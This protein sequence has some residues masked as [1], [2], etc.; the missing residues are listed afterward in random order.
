MIVLSELNRSYWED[1]ARYLHFTKLTEGCADVFFFA[2]LFDYAVIPHLSGKP[3]WCLEFE[4]PNRY[5][6][7][8]LLRPFEQVQDRI[9]RIF[10]ICPYT[11]EWLNE[12]EGSDRRVPVYFPFAARHVPEPQEKTFDVI[13]TGHVWSGVLEFV[14]P[15]AAHQYCLVSRR[16][17]SDLDDMITHEDVG[18]FE[19]LRLIARSR[20]AVVHN[21]LF[22]NKKH[23]A[24]VKRLPGADRNKAF[25]QIFQRRDVSDPVV[26]QLKSRLFEAAFCRTLILCARDDW[27]VAER[28]FEPEQEFLYYRRGALEET[29]NQ[30]LSDWGRYE[31]VIER[32]FQRAI[33]QYT[34]EAFTRSYLVGSS[35]SR[36]PAGK[37]SPLKRRTGLKGA[38][39]RLL[40]R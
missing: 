40:A 30:V 28:Y 5:F 10:T 15:M 35:G 26:P 29:L 18:Y 11:A 7:D 21:L 39:T 31:G 32:A 17:G 12:R 23:I 1:P 22:P 2:G 9:D 34:T 20:V 8:G 27:N 6:L 33:S 37:V 24:H 13:Y 4:E 14:A 3:I 19:K 38:V 25:S 16:V 36:P